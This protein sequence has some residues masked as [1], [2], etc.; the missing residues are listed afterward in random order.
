MGIPWVKSYVYS[1]TQ[2]GGCQAIA[3]LPSPLCYLPAARLCLLAGGGVFRRGRLM[4]LRFALFRLCLPLHQCAG[5]GGVAG[6]EE[7]D[8]V[9]GLQAR[10]AGGDDLLAATGDHDEQAALG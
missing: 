7:G 10:V 6:D 9:A 2:F 4:P 8:V 1:I 3:P 5:L